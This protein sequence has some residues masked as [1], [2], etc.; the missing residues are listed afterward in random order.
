MINDVKELGDFLSLNEESKIY[1]LDIFNKL[2]REGTPTI[3]DELFDYLVDQLQDPEA[4]RSK[5]GFKVG[6]ERKQKLPVIM[7]SMNKVKT[8]DDINDWIKSKKLDIK[9]KV[10]ITPK[11]DGCSF[12]TKIGKRWKLEGWTRGDGVEGQYSP[13]H[14]KKIL[15]L[16]PLD[17]IDNMYIIGEVMMKKAV[18]AEKY[19]QQYKNSR[20]L[21]AGLMNSKEA[22]PIL[23]DCIFVAYNTGDNG[24]FDTKDEVIEFLN[25]N[26]NASVVPYHITTIA[27]LTHEKLHDLFLSW[28]TEFDLD[29]VIIELQDI[30]H[31]E[32]LGRETS[33][34]N[35]CYARAY[36]FEGNFAITKLIGIENQVSK[37]GEVRPVGVIEPVELDGVTINRVSLKNYKNIFENNMGVGSTVRII[38]SGQVIPEITDVINGVTPVL[39]KVCPSCGSTLIWNDSKVH[40]VCNNDDCETKNL[41]KVISFFEILEVDNVKEG[42]VEQLF[43]AEYTSV[44][45]ICKM[46]IS[47]FLKVDGF[48]ESKANKVYNS[49][50]EKLATAKIETLQHASG[51]FEGLGSKKLVLF[52]D[53]NKYWIN[54]Y[55]PP[56]NIRED[57]LKI[58]GLSDKSID[59]YENGMVNFS[60]WIRHLPINI[61][62]LINNN[63]VVKPSTGQ[64][65]GKTFVFT[66]YRD[67]EAEAKLESLGATIG[68]GVSKNVTYLV[69]KEKGSGSGKEQKA[70]ELG[71]TILDKEEFNKLLNTF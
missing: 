25:V 22:S 34:Q 3:T 57:L 44:A 27:E 26:I 4:Y 14:I 52:K 2:Y 63:E 28:N 62:N 54:Q 40:L 55:N 13:E 49:I 7:A 29:G 47:D 38:R 61:D 16:D 50:H 69:M 67:K 41:Q 15:D 8:M 21:V 42:V 9:T 31:Q 12:V 1:N 58:K 53:V 39:P 23:E 18:F 17:S 66:G 51:L 5:I 30:K 37:Y 56:T 10:V 59:I 35:P 65:T 20:N 19:S 6:D 71:I 33:S 60:L 48:K 46:E 64:L 70:I 43:D 68:S 36:K 45:A 11:F 24:Q 32:S